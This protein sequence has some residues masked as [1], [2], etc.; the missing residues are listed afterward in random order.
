MPLALALL[1]DVVAT[2]GRIWS[3]GS[4]NRLTESS[5]GQWTILLLGESL[6]LLPFVAFVPA[7][8]A[9]HKK[10]ETP[11]LEA[12]WIPNFRHPT[13]K[14]LWIGIVGAATFFL[15]IATGFRLA[16]PM[17]SYWEV[18]LFVV[19][20]QLV[21]LY[22]VSRFSVVFPAISV[23][24]PLGL[25]GGWLATRECN[26][27]VFFAH[28][29]ATLPLVLIF[30]ICFTLLYIPAFA[31]LNANPQ[32]LGAAISSSMQSAVFVITPIL[33]CIALVFTSCA[34]EIYRQL[35]K[36]NDHSEST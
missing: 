3:R 15:P 20:G 8:I 26:I 12:S 16:L 22:F 33:F 28:F 4:Y 31:I 5:P 29:L 19:L 36:P 10:I 30:L 1:I 9:F 21:G 24:R 17:E 14:Y 25:V 13:A 32:V 23:T 27:K 6:F 7:L 2:E 34:S 18:P 11:N 35:T